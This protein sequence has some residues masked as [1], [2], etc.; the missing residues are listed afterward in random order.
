MT[1]ET[2]QFL[3]QRLRAVALVLTVALSMTMFGEL[4]SRDLPTLWL[5]I[6]AGR[7]PCRACRCQSD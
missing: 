6:L 5:R 1:D 4:L 3:R 7:G 2:S